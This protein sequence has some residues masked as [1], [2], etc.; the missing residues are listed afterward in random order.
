MTNSPT[1]V[2]AAQRVPAS[3]RCSAADC[4]SPVDGHLGGK[5]CAAH[6]RSLTLTAAVT[7]ALVS[8]LAATSVPGIEIGS[9]V[10][11]DVSEA[12][13]CF[14]AGLGLLVGAA[15]GDEISVGAEP[16]RLL[17]SGT[18]DDQRARWRINFQW[19]AGRGE[20]K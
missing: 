9:P 3:I 12:G 2:S 8:F 19:Q 4:N 5:W 11:R 1:T 13:E 14:A 16:I 20:P 17:P 6:R 18:K 7:D 15:F 10:H